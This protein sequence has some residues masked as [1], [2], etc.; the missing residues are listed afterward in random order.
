[1][2]S[3]SLLSV[4]IALP[5]SITELPAEVKHPLTL[6]PLPERPP[7][8]PSQG[9]PK[10]PDPSQ[11]SCL[12]PNIPAISG[13]PRCH[14]TANN[15]NALRLLLVDAPQHKA[16]VDASPHSAGRHRRATHCDPSTPELPVPLASPQTAPPNGTFVPQPHG[17]LG[18]VAPSHPEPSHPASHQAATDT[19][20]IK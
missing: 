17:T 1:M 16:L 20:F 3:G 13:S 11:L 12:L 2:H 15:L 7:P 10:G 6:H 8:A 4:L 5:L 19:T 14:S 9:H 18:V